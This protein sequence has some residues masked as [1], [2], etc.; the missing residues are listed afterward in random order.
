MKLNRKTL[1]SLCVAGVLG[2][3]G[4]STLSAAT[5]DR[6]GFH[7]DPHPTKNIGIPA[8]H[9]SEIPR[10]SAPAPAP[11]PTRA[12]TPAPQV[13]DHGSYSNDLIRVTKR[14]LDGTRVG[15]KFGYQITVEALRDI[16]NLDL[17]EYIP[18][19]VKLDSTAPEAKVDG[20]TL[21]WF[22]KAMNKGETRDFNV[23][24]IP[25]KEG[26]FDVCTTVTADPRICIGMIAGLPVLTIDKSGPATSELDQSV[27]WDIVV[28]NKGTV[29]AEK[30]TVEDVLPQGFTAQSP[31]KA[32]LG[33]INPGESKR[34]QV[35]A[36]GST[37]GD[38]TNT[39]S[40]KYEGGS[41]V[42]DT[43]PV[44]IVQSLLAIEKTGPEESFVF[45]PATY[46]ITVK[47]EGTTTLRDLRVEDTLPS[48]VELIDSGGGTVHGNK[49]HWDLPSLAAGQSR[50]YRV[51][52]S[53]NQPGTTVNTASVHSATGLTAT[54]TARTEWF[55]VPGVQLEVIDSVDPIRV[56]E[57]TVYT[58]T[59][60]N[61]GRFRP[62]DT[63]IRF[64]LTDNIRPLSISGSE[65]G[66]I[67]GQVVTFPAATLQPGRDLVIQITAEGVARGVGVGTME[68]EAD[69]L[70]RTVSSQEPTN[71]Y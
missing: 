64:T 57:R 4:L 2:S 53:A 45:N 9:F 54:D 1:L 26:E 16:A 10:Q 67:D 69:F 62:V 52:F 12:A 38:F 6:L 17:K 68:L 39:A 23:V 44:T 8:R 25:E 11:A 19:D 51:R 41:P 7:A 5:A 61:Q 13:S 40:A 15:G 47:N 36:L 49:I 70:G 29:A 66:T 35:T 50:D 37:T 34:F 24:V 59:V 33:T 21:S 48:G 60:K 65:Q 28:G 31:L 3:L 46:V 42:T 22:V 58:L 20:N 43:A 55:G 18:G 14:Q 71:V 63:T 30:V 27:T 32:D 56:G